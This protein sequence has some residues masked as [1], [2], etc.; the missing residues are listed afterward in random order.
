M[1]GTLSC[2]LELM[3]YTLHAIFLLSV[4]FFGILPRDKEISNYKARADW[5]R[6][7]DVLWNIHARVKALRDGPGGKVQFCFILGFFLG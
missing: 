1:R 5:L 6:W 2:K 4:W 3:Y 7:G